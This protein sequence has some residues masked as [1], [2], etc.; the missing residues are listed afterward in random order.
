MTILSQVKWDGVERHERK[1]NLNR[2]NGICFMLYLRITLELMLCGA[3]DTMLLDQTAVR[4][5]CLR[6]AKKIKQ[7]NVHKNYQPLRTTQTNS[8]VIGLEPMAQSNFAQTTNENTQNRHIRLI[9][10]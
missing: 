4:K 10:Y 7:Q 9:K 5:K 8:K 1:S 3:K 6:I 2:V